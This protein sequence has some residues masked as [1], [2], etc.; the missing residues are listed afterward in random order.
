MDADGSNRK[1]LTDQP[2]GINCDEA[3]WSADGRKIM[4][5]S[6]RP[7][8]EGIG[9]WIMDADGSNQRVFT[10]DTSERGRPSW[11][12]VRGKR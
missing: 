11:Q 10:T 9:N 2:P 12:P 5:A 8:S 1:Q 7:C 6:N 4:F 3:A